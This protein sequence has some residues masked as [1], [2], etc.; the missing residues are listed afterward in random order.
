MY[1]ISGISQNCGAE[2]PRKRNLFCHPIDRIFLFQTSHLTE[3]V[4]LDR[5]RRLLIFIKVNSILRLILT[6]TK[7]YTLYNSLYYFHANIGLSCI[8]FGNFIGHVLILERTISTLFTTKYSQ[9]KVPIFGIC[10]ISIL[11][12]FFF[13]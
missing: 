3:K 8:S 12:G 2:E 9:P 10:C 1:K 6:I 11:V 13:Y 4:P 5:S 7:Q